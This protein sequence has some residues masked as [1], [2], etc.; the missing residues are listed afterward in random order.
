M[1]Q[2][3]DAMAKGGFFDDANSLIHQGEFTQALLLLLK[4]RGYAVDRFPDEGST[5]AIE[6]R[7]GECYEKINDAK[8]ALVAYRRALEIIDSR[9]EPQRAA[10]MPLRAEAQEGLNRLERQ[11]EAI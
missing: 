3:I 8:N 7:I 5:P 11:A 6:V 4:C 1:N 2:A 10:F 9:A